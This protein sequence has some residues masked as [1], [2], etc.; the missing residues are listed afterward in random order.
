M[1]VFLFKWTASRSAM[2]FRDIS[3]ALSH[4]VPTT[5]SEPWSHLT[6]PYDMALHQ[7][8]VPPPGHIMS[9]DN[10][11]TDAYGKSVSE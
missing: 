10:V 3:K 2:G 6:E 9:I 11:Y 7:P 8:E 4:P 5:A 1:M